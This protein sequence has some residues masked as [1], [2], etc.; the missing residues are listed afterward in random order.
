MGD[1]ANIVVRDRYVKDPGDREAVVLYS[2]WGGY[3]MPETLRKALARRQRW[4]DESYLARII[5]DTMTEGD[6]GSET[7]YG[8][9]TRMPDNE[10]DLLVLDSERVYRLSEAD[11]KADGFTKLG[12][13]ESI[14]FAEYVAAPERTWDNLTDTPAANRA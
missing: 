8:I 13:C 6:H 12:Q 4:D 2:H 9:S 10:Y 3:E 1:R 7:G 11:Y 14:G 5:F